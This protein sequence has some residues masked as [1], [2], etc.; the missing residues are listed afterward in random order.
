M[1]SIQPGIVVKDE[2]GDEKT[3]YPTGIEWILA[4][5]IRG[6]KWAEDLINSGELEKIEAARL[7]DIWK[8]DSI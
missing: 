1:E 5:A 8:G 3:I 6:C 2:Y 7:A 4:F